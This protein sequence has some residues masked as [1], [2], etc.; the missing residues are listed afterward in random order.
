MQPSSRILFILLALIYS[1]PYLLFIQM[2]SADLWNS[3]VPPCVRIV[4]TFSDRS[5]SW[6]PPGT[7]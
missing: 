7:S 6:Q 5:W 2:T 3:S 4:V 1:K